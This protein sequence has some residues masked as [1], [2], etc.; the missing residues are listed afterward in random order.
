MKTL[1]TVLALVSFNAFA[2][3]VQVTEVSAHSVSSAYGISADFGI[4]ESLG[5]A[6]AEIT[7]ASTFSDSNDTYLR[8]QVPGL[9]VV[10]DQVVLNVEG[11]N[12]VC[13]NIRPVGIFRY[14]VAKK[15][16]NC[17]FVVETKTTQVDD[18]YTVRTVKKHVLSLETK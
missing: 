12:V 10:G 17:A 6:W 9:S 3:K 14:R 18:G 5:R 1:I 2:A 7:L 8:A 16:K 4:N 15:T 11:Q 13:A